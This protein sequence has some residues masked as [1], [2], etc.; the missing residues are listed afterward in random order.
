MLVAISVAGPL[1]ALA[2]TEKG[3]HILANMGIHF[4]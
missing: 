3:Q 1:L 4:E 2:F